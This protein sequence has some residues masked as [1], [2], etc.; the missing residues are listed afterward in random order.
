MHD[1]L[2]IHITVYTQSHLRIRSGELQNT[3]GCVTRCWRTIVNRRKVRWFGHVVKSK[4]TLANTSL[5]GKVESK[6]SQGLP[7]RQ[8][9]D[10]VK[11]SRGLGS[12]GMWRG[13]YDRATWRKRG[14]RVSRNGLNGLRHSRRFKINHYL[15][16]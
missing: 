2:Y 13:P 3:L 7:E 14:N 5:Q 8:W 10:D 6:I 15:R 16:L 9:L 1:K 11:E 12:K 4:K